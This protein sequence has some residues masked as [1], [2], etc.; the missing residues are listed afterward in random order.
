MLPRMSSAQLAVDFTNCFSD[1]VGPHGLD[2]S[3]LTSA[4]P[5]L[6][7][8]TAQ[9]EKT[10]DTGWERWRGLP[11]DPMRK[12]H[13]KGVKKLVR[14]HRSRTNNLVVLGIGGSALGNIALHSALKPA[15]YN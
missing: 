6:S 10:R 15:T 3:A 7:E 4:L 12:E 13:V 1:R 9:L 8:C 5:R 2:S 14:K 11:F